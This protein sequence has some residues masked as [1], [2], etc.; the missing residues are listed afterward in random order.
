MNTRNRIE[1]IAGLVTV[2][3]LVLG[4]Y[5]VLR[6]FMIAVVWT[7]ILCYATWPIYTFI[8][9]IV[10]NRSTLAASL[11]TLLVVSVIIVPFSV[12]IVSLSDDIT[13]LIRTLR[14]VRE[15]G[16]PSTPAW[17]IKL[18]WIGPYL[19]E[20][21]TQLP[22]DSATLFENLK[23]FLSRF[24]Q[25]FVAR[26]WDFGHGLFQL[27]L[28]IFIAFFFYR[29]GPYLVEKIH[30]SVNRI[31]GD[32]TQH[33]IRVVSGTI[34]GVVYGILGTAAAQ[35]LLAGLGFWAAG[36]PVPLL[37]GI[38]TFFFSLLPAGPPL[39]W[40]PASVW[41]F[42]NG[43][44]NW[45]IFLLLWG[46]LVISGVDNIL[47]PY[48]ISKGSSLPFVLVFLGV[49]GGVLAFG[50]IGVFLGPILLAIGYTLLMEWS[51]KPISQNP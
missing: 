42:L 4:C 37:L 13:H 35:S 19:D 10:N 7:A 46:F 40:I 31:A 15:G 5:A 29:D 48:L 30:N 1:Q 24:R 38:L 27:G 43:E 23:M 50:F 26:A 33:L 32:R 16:L 41:L 47:K 2:I 25:W 22:H 28:S 34:N 45:G 12:L 18:P 6:P 20:W 11:M 21:W 17:I 44:A 14:H 3:F 36:T 39:I 9:R 8:L 49:L 51:D